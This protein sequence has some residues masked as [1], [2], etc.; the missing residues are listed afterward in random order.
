MVAN[1]NWTDATREDIYSGVVAMDT[2]RVGFFVGE[3][4]SL[5]CC[6]EDVG[7]AYLNSN[8]KEKVFIIVGPKFGH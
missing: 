3:L 5:K 6:V 2:V 7:N 8:T 4:N 1:G